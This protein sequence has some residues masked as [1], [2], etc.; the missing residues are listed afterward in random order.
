[1]IFT[2]RKK[3]SFLLIFAVL[4]HA[5]FLLQGTSEKYSFLMAPRYVLRDG[6][7]FNLVFTNW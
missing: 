3:N 6:I 2:W 5:G 7:Y 4:D 1:M